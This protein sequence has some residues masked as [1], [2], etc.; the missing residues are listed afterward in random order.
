MVPVIIVFLLCERIKFHYLWALLAFFLA[1]FTD[2]FD[3]KIARSKNEI[4]NFGIF[5]DPIAD[6]ILIISILICF[7]KLNLINIIVVILIIFRDFLVTSLRL[8][9]KQNEKIICA[10]NLGKAKTVFQVTL[11]SSILFAECLKEFLNLGL[12]HANYTHY[13][14]VLTILN[15]VLSWLMALVTVF[16]GLVYLH[17]NFELIS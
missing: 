14:E 13:C 16:S 11:I 7:V 5:L 15:L 6:K 3:G 8:L 17:K 10:N 12:I 9:A 4:T 2:Y 1:S